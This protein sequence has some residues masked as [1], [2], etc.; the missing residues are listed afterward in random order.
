MQSDNKKSLGNNFISYFQGIY[1]RADNGSRTRDL[2]ITNVALYHLSYIS[3]SVE[4]A[5]TRYMV[6]YGGKDVKQFFGENFVQK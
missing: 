5:S 6:L 3:I 1:F 2:Y 4:K